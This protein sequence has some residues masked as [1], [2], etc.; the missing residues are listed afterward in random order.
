MVKDGWNRLIVPRLV[1]GRYLKDTR[2]VAIRSDWTETV[3]RPAVRK[4]TTALPYMLRI[5]FR[6]VASLGQ[7]QEAKSIKLSLTGVS[8]P[9]RHREKP[10]SQ[11]KAHAP[12]D[13]LIQRIYLIVKS[14]LVEFISIRSSIDSQVVCYQDQIFHGKSTAIRILESFRHYRFLY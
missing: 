10:C 5:V 6:S 4:E 7:G 14:N 8:W 13:L 12:H 3:K 1:T 2:G 9:A 11:Q